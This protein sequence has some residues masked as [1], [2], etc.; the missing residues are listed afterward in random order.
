MAIDGLTLANYAQTPLPA[1]ILQPSS[2]TTPT[3][4]PQPPTTPGCWVWTPSGCSAQPA[5]NP[6]QWTRDTWGEENL[7]SGSD[8]GICL[9]QRKADYDAWCGDTDSKTFWVAPS[10]KATAASTCTF[11]EQVNGVYCDTWSDDSDRPIKFTR[12]SPSTCSTIVAPAA[13]DSDFLYLNT[14]W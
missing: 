13:A 12:A 3:S 14:E 5:Y 9:N 2:A 6:Q 1:T 4:T 10:Y 8:Q 7:G 11:E